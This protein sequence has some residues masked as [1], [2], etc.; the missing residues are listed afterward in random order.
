MAAEGRQPSK[1]EGERA[2]QPDTPGSGHQHIVKIG[3]FIAVE[4]CQ[5]SGQRDHANKRKPPHYSSVNNGASESRHR[6]SLSFPAQLQQVLAAA[7]EVV[8][9]MGGYAVIRVSELFAER[10]Q[11]NRKRQVPMEFLDAEWVVKD[12]RIGQCFEDGPSDGIDMSWS[13]ALSQINRQGNSVNA[14]R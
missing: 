13:N 3:G 10:R 2:G 5:R 4:H 8:P 7:Q 11:H 12:I 1:S 9:S 6:D 14:G